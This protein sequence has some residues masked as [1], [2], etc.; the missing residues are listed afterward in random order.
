[1]ST[2]GVRGGLGVQVRTSVLS[3]LAPGKA[4]TNQAT[5]LTLQARTMGRKYNLR[6]N[7]AEALGQT[8][9]VSPSISYVLGSWPRIK[10]CI[11]QCRKGTRPG[12]V[13]KFWLIGNGVYNF[14]EMD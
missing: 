13:A 10:D 1:M 12:Q 9:L 2:S 5:S 14:R 7:T 8:S 6:G 11:P 4:Q 3:V